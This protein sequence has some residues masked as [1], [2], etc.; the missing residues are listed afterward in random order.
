MLSFMMAFAMMPWIAADNSGVAS[1]AVEPCDSTGTWGDWTT[2]KPAAGKVYDS[3]TEWRYRTRS[4][5][6]TSTSSSS[7]PDSSWNANGSARDGAYG[8]WSSWSKTKPTSYSYREIGQTNVSDN[9]GYTRYNWYYG[10][11]MNGSR[12]FTYSVDYAKNHG[13]EKVTMWTKGNTLTKEKSYDGHQ[14]Y[15][16]SSKVKYANELWWLESTQAVAATTHVEY[17]YRDR[18]WVYYWWKWGSW[19]SWSSW[20][21]T[22]Y[23]NADTRQVESRTTYR[24]WTPNAHTWN[25]GVVKKAAGYT[26][27]GVK[28]HTCTVCGATKSTTIPS[29]NPAPVTPARA[30]IVS[31]KVKSKKVTVKWNRIKAKTK[32]YQVAVKNKK[33]KEVKVYNVKASS[34]SKITKTLKL[35][36]GTYAVMVRAYNVVNG[37]TIYGKWSNVKVGKV[38]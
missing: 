29:L 15:K 13:G 23:T 4:K 6:T 17:R 10:T 28:T 24:V 5:T 26:H 27:T 33:T 30:K 2:T 9:N 8:S 38:K 3:R 14:A 21:T 37:E 19:G 12:W 18:A 31:A 7:A 32:G 1:A 16:Y 22:S 20:G 11:Y 34:K 36:K 25:G 35:K